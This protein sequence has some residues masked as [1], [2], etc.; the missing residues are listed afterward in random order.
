M[1]HARETHII[2]RRTDRRYTQRKCLDARF[3]PL[4]LPAF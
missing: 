1:R 4:T 2:V 3:F